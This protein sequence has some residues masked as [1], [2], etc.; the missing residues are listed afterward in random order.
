MPNLPGF[1]APAWDHTVSTGDTPFERQMLEPGRLKIFEEPLE[2][3]VGFLVIL[4]QA[5]S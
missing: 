1:H 3:H 4:R 2:F 5:G